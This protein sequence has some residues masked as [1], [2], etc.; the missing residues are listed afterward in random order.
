MSKLIDMTGQRVGML[1]V[2]RQAESKN[3]KT[4]W[5]CRCDCGATTTV[6]RSHLSAKTRPTQ[7]CGCLQFSGRY[8][9]GLRHTRLYNT[10]SGMIQRCTNPKAVNYR[11]YGGRGVTVCPEWRVSFEAFHEWALANGYADDL[12]IERID[13]DGNYEPTNCRWATR[14]EQNNNTRRNHCV[15]YNGVTRTIAEWSDVT[16]LS[17]DLIEQ[18]L[19]RGWSAEKTLTTKLK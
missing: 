10:W 3:G 17:R 15:E 13:P 18:R 11:N 16:G 1:V 12:T 8:R 14:K 2:I 9:H 7:S 6:A 4:F 5:L 19:K